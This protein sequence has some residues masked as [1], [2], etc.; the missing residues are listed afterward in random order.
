MFKM[1]I[2]SRNICCFGR[3]HWD[4]L[5]LWPC[6]QVWCH[7]CVQKTSPA[8]R[9]RIPFHSSHRFCQWYRAGLPSH[10]ANKCSLSPWKKRW[11]V[12]LWN[13]EKFWTALHC[14]IKCCDETEK[15][16]TALHCGIKCCGETDKFWTALY[17]GINFSAWA[18]C[19]RMLAG[20]ETASWLDSIIVC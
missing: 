18:W 9:L 4:A 17:C 16:W 13:W 8:G 20:N 15:F 1:V 2:L 10:Q 19:Q 11:V 7:R 6:V 12:L 5:G 3:L 14:G